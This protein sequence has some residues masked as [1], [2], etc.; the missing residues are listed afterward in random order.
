MH[1][2]SASKPFATC[3]VQVETNKALQ[4]A[5]NVHTAGLWQGQTLKNYLH[6][7]LPL[8]QNSC[9]TA[10]L[11]INLALG[12]F[13]AEGTILHLK[14]VQLGITAVRRSLCV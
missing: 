7:P 14:H 1:A 11:P 6:L 9:S 2:C 5:D 12:Q 4:R 8:G 3:C 13:H 10:S